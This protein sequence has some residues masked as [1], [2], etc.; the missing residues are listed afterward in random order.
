MRLCGTNGSKYVA[1]PA[2]RDDRNRWIDGIVSPGKI[3]AVIAFGATAKKAWTDYTKVNGPPS[4][5]AVELLTHPTF[6]ESAGGSKAQQAENTKKMLTQWNKARERLFPAIA[7]KD[8]PSTPLTF[9][10]DAFVKAVPS[11][12]QCAPRCPL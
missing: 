2:V 9:Y 8:V 6:P 7:H 11:H 4:A 5:I 12:G 10:G 3:E 1:K